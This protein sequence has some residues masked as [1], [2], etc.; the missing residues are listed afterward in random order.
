MKEAKNATLEKPETLGA[1]KSLQVRSL[2]PSCLRPRFLLPPK[3]LLGPGFCSQ[4]F[5]L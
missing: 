2:T 1:V 3:T 5:S 4:A